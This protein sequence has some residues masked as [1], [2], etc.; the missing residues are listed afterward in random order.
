MQRCC[1]KLP[2]VLQSPGVVSGLSTLSCW[3]QRGTWEGLSGLEQR[4]KGSLVNST[5]EAMENDK[6]FKAT[7]KNLRRLVI[8]VNV[9]NVPV[10]CKSWV[11]QCLTE[12]LLKG[13]GRNVPGRAKK[14]T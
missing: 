10:V 13:C 5:L 7:A 6:D 1:A 8:I 14:K 3:L 12:F 4:V 2:K 9:H 11:S